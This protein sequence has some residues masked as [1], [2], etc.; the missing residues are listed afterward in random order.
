MWKR[1]F[2]AGAALVAVACGHDLP[3]RPAPVTVRAATAVV[4]TTNITS[5]RTVPGI[6]RSTTVSPLAA[7]VVGNVLR[8]HVSEGDFVKAGQLLVEIDAREGRAQTDAASSAV[9]AAAANATLAETTYRRYAA[10]RERRSVS[11]QELDNVEAQTKAAQAELD[12]ARANAAQARTFLDHSSVRAPMDGVVTARFVDPGAQAA[13]GMPLITIEDPRAL[14][15]EAHVPEGLLV[16]VG[17]R[18]RVDDV[19]GVVAQ[20][21]PSIDAGSRTSLIKIGVKTPLSSGAFVRVQIPT[22]S[23]DALAVPPSAIL[24]RG[25]LTSVFVVGSDGIARM[26]LITLGEQN[27]VL[28][29]LEPGERIVTEPAKVRDGAKV[30]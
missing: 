26:R 4:Q 3:E 23:R 28:S 30:S 5:M 22:G 17:D 7:R 15:V 21:Q 18:V 10:L 24:R 9:A 8:V 19:E 16:R 20:V 14:R 11:Q 6:V 12:R 2:S 13:P 1:F 27:E 25:A 29:G